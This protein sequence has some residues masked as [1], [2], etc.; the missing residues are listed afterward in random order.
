MV[1]ICQIRLR[2][3]ASRIH[4]SAIHLVEV[5]RIFADNG[6]H[7]VATGNTCDTIREAGIPAEKVKNRRTL[8]FLYYR[9]TSLFFQLPAPVSVCKNGK[10]W[11]TFPDIAA[12][13]DNAE[14]EHMF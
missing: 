12:I 1:L 9:T 11:L 10:R 7:I 8:N 13:M 6:F 4:T 14:T 5:A 3:R 2:L